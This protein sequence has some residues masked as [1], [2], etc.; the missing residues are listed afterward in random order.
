MLT[1]TQ[2]LAGKIQ[3]LINL[4][5]PLQSFVVEQLGSAMTATKTVR[6]G[7]AIGDGT[8]RLGVFTASAM[9]RR[10]DG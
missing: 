5:Y 1:Y 9:T 6:L 8:A 4:S 10:W 7:T 2:H 3:I